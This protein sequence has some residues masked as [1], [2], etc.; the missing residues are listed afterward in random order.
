M[1]VGL[2]IICP[3]LPYA[4]AVCG[5]DAIYFDPENIE[6]LRL[7]IVTLEDRL[8]AGWWPNWSEALQSVPENWER[9]A[10]A[11]L[12]LTADQDEHNGAN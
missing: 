6:S 9:V 12:R 8:R 2:P 11:M 4:H 1:W 10:S 3:D 7:A 5:A